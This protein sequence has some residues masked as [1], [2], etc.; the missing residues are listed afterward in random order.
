MSDIEKL[1]EL[2]TWED[3]YKYQEYDNDIIYD[4]IKFY[5]QERSHTLC[6]ILSSS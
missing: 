5:F 6:L 2:L 1:M 3:K 4:H